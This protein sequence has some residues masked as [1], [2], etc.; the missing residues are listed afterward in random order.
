MKTSFI[1]QKDFLS[2]DWKDEEIRLPGFLATGFML[3][4]EKS[5]EQN[6]NITSVS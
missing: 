2:M 3:D 4:Y 6:I 5:N 1:S